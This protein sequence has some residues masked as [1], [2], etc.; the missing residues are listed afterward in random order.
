MRKLALLTLFLTVLV[1]LK[2]RAFNT[3]TLNPAD[4]TLAYVAMPLAVSD[5]CAVR[6]VQTDQVASLTAYMDQAQVSP[7]G[8][9][10][11]F[12]SFTAAGGGLTSSS[13]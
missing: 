3:T 4:D 9:I 11:V 12:R 5:V 6:G 13:G 7:E 1:P 2:A 8:F 10:D